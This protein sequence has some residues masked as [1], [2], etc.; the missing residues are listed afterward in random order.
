MSGGITG[1][2]GALRRYVVQ[3]IGM[4]EATRQIA[5]AAV[6]KITEIIDQQ[7]S[8]GTD[9]YGNAWV[10]LKT[11][12]QPFSGRDS[13]GRVDVRLV[14]DGKAIRTTVVYPMHFHQDGTHSGGRKAARKLRRA[15]KRQGV[16]IGKALS[17]ERARAAGGVHC[18]QRPIIPDSGDAP[19]KWTLAIQEAAK[20]EM[21]ALGAD[22]KGAG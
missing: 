8:S 11:G 10:P 3:L 14:D 21:A 15:S 12:Q 22:L 1:D 18:P 7:F 13:A 16:D 17:E 5:R 6:P 20:A 9:P 19:D 2:Y 4:K